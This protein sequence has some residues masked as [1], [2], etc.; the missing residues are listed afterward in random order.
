MH[1]LTN[2]WRELRRR[3]EFLRENNY[4][5]V[6]IT[7]FSNEG[8]FSILIYRYSILTV[9]MNLFF[10]LI[11]LNC[12]IKKYPNDFL[13]VSVPINS[14]KVTEMC[15]TKCAFKLTIWRYPL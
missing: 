4:E 14:H 11:L 2:T 3:L 5:M 7:E 15:Q 1:L 13:V 8:F 10:M 12:I 9:I 6:N